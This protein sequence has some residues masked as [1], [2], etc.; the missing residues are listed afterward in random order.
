MVKIV[1]ALEGIDIYN[2]YTFT[3]SS[4]NSFQGTFEKGNLHLDGNQALAYV[5]ER[6]ALDNGDI[7]RG[8]HQN[9]VIQSMIDK[10]TEPMI[11][12]RIDKLLSS[13]EGTFKTNIIMDEIY[14]LAQMQL[15]DMAMWNIITYSLGGTSGYETVASLDENNT[16]SVVYLDDEQIQFVQDVVQQVYNGELIEQDN[17][18]K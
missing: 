11:I 2:P 13:M 3:T 18:P 1:D 10:L 15:D 14:A 9:I 5:R 16:Y 17:L 12:T 7:G 4:T 6:K 8:E